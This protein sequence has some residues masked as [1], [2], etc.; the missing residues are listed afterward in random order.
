M[1]LPIRF[2]RQKHNA[3]NSDQISR[4]IQRWTYFDIHSVALSKNLEI[5]QPAC[6]D[7]LRLPITINTVQPDFWIIFQFFLQQTELTN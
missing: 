3:Q 6:L 4:R 7:V 1:Y 5:L 2:E